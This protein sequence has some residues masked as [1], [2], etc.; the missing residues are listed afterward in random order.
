MSG[1]VPT[2]GAVRLTDDGYQIVFVRRL[3]KPIEKVWAALTVPERIG[4]W[5]APVTIEPALRIGARFNLDFADGK[6]RTPGEILALEPPRLI[7]WTWPAAEG[8]A[9]PAPGVVRFELAPEGD[10]CRLTLTG[11]GPGRPHP[12]ELAGW[13]THLEGLE[14]AAEG[15]RTALNPERELAHERRYAEVVARL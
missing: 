9:G 15:V 14:G 11:S 10:G 1:P 8:E 12:N 7:A 4:D 2:D 3:R 5:L 6:R 13:H